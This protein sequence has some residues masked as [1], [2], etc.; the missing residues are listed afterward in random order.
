MCGGLGGVWLLRLSPPHLLPRSRGPGGQLAGSPWAALGQCRR[1]C[2]SVTRRVCGC[3]GV[4]HS[5]AACASG[6]SIEMKEVV[7][8]SATLERVRVPATFPRER[9]RAWRAA[10]AA[11]PV[12]RDAGEIGQVIRGRRPTRG[13][14]AGRGGGAAGAAGADRGGGSGASA[15]DHGAGAGAA[16]GRRAAH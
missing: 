3:R 16:P 4:S 11:R 13:V 2:S 6:D 1:A 7:E 8:V 14:A 15:S 12:G 5:P 10:S 9:V